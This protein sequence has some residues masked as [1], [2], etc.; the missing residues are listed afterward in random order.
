MPELNKRSRLLEERSHLAIEFPQSDNRVFRAYVPFLENPKINE[1]GTSNLAEYNL[2][3]RP[4]SMFSYGGSPSR[5]INITFKISL[6]NLMQLQS[7]EGISEKFQRSFNLFFG[8]KERSKK[9]FG[10]RKEIALAEEDVSVQNFDSNGFDDNAISLEDDFTSDGEFRASEDDLA[11]L[12]EQSAFGAGDDIKAGVGRDHASIHRKH[13][14]DLIG[15]VTGSQPI[16]DGI[17][18]QLIG[19][20]GGD[21][22]TSPN[23][24]ERSLSKTLNMIYVWVNLIRATTLNNATNTTQ[25]P[26][27]VRLTHGAMYNNVPCVVEDY[28]IKIVDESGF[29][30]QSLTPKQLEVTMSLRENRTGSSDGFEAG[31]IAAGDEIVG[32]EAI[33][34]SNNIDPYNGLINND[35]GYET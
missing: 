19:F 2:L 29:E 32:W 17:A 3:G 25:G 4:G 26:P 20:L 23:Q 34:D 8:D 28:S 11:N 10:L 30:I 7:T 1:R 9:R 31:A 16:F 21:P 18:N 13:Y 6:L 35:K 33:I 22:I 14:R 27:I 5:D 15:A 12:E 24:D